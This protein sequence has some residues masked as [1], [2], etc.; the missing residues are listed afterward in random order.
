MTSCDILPCYLLSCSA[1]PSVEHSL[2][3]NAMNRI[4]TIWAIQSGS[5]RL[6]Y[7]PW[8]AKG[9]DL[10]QC[11]DV[12]GPSV[13]TWRLAVGVSAAQAFTADQQLQVISVP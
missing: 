7:L 10:M 4:T 3:Y 11:C 9:Q 13:E 5:G 2:Y 6:L 1:A 12:F 8:T